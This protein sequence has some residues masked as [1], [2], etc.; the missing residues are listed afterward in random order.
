MVELFIIS[1]QTHIW[2]GT[3]NFY[4]TARAPSDDSDQPAHP[5]SLIIVF[6]MHP[7]GSQGS[8]ASSSG[9][10]R[11]W[12]AFMD[13]LAK[14]SIRWVFMQYGRHTVSRLICD[15]GHVCRI[16]WMIAEW[17]WWRSRSCLCSPCRCLLSQCSSFEW[18]AIAINLISCR[19]AILYTHRSMIKT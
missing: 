9:Q 11:L 14:P 10:R 7:A 5:G 15:L 18:E 2:A 6:T 17:Q 12:S 16:P 19:L 3:Q 13:A 4:N 8:N 1:I